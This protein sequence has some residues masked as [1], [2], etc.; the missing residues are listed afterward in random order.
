MSE[1]NGEMR[2]VE[3]Q[4]RQRKATGDDSQPPGIVPSP[5]IELVLKLIW[6]AFFLYLATSKRPRLSRKAFLLDDDADKHDE[7][8]CCYGMP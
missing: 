1:G 2:E 7:R 8:R 6:C 4:R 3:L 5:Y